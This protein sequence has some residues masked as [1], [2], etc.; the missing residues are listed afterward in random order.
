MEWKRY[1]AASTPTLEMPWGRQIRGS[2]IRTCARARPSQSSPAASF[3]MNIDK[4]RSIMTVLRNLKRR[5]GVG[6]FAIVDEWDAD[7]CAIGIARPS[8]LERLVYISTWNKP[9]DLFYVE[10]E[11]RDPIEAIESGDPQLPE[12]RENADF[13]ELVDIIQ[14]HLN[15]RAD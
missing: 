12:R 14:K 15:L 9:S 4:D 2:R 5:F 11:S 7:R 8:D 6:A 3:E 13:D 1:E 10:I